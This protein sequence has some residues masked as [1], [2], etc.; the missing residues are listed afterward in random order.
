MVQSL[1]LFSQAVAGLTGIVFV[2]LAWRLRDGPTPAERLFGWL[3][4]VVGGSALVFAAVAPSPGAYHLLWLNALFAIPVVFGLFCFEY[5]GLAVPRTRIQQ[6]AVLTPAILAA[7]AGTALSVVPSASTSGAMSGMMQGAMTG[8]RPVFTT[9]SL[10]PVASTL[11]G[12]V[13]DL[14]IYYASGVTLVAVGVIASAVGRYRHLAAGLGLSLAGTGVWPWAAYVGM[15]A[16]AASVARNVALTVIAGGYAVSAAGAIVAVGHYGLFD[17]QPQA[18]TIGPETVLDTMPAAVLV[19]DREDRVLRLNAPAERCFETSERAAVG[20][21]VETVLGVNADRLRQAGDEG[22]ALATAEGERQF[23]PTLAPIDDGRNIAGTAVVLRDVTQRRTREQRLAVLNRVLRH[24]YR[25]ELN[26]IRGYADL[27]G[28]DSGEAARIQSLADDLLSLS[29]RARETQRV[30]ALDVPADPQTAVGAVLESVAEDLRVAYPEVEV[31]VAVPDGAVAAVDERVFTV[32]A[33]NVLENACEHNDAASP[34]V[35]ASVD[36][37]DEGLRLAVSDNGP[38]IP[39]METGVLAAGTENPLQ[40]G[41]GLGLWTVKWGVTRMGG[42]LS[43]AE[44]TPRG[45]VVQIRLPAADGPAPAA[46][47]ASAG[48][49]VSDD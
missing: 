45:T 4:G 24:N 17:S 15:P 48:R 43:F 29:E 5:Y 18:G 16:L 37:T 34:V 40:H 8:G 46:A 30:M 28:D 6:A 19:L 36:R 47:T 1:T 39:D 26:A 20:T 2:A 13:R 23:H 38:G 27:V 10:G 3:L 21:T 11:L 42:T 25:N 33:R 7:A 44:N 32:V 49:A 41:Q 22:V 14:G 31:T 9:L 35:V 12:A